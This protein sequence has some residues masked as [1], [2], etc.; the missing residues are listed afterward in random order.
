MTS[1]QSQAQPA[2]PPILKSREI[3]LLMR[4]R[5]LTLT[6]VAWGLLIYFMRD[7]W[8]LAYEY[9]DDLLLDIDPSNLFHWV[10]IWTRIAPFF[11]VAAF[12][13]AWVVILSLLRRRAI[14]HTGR[15]RGKKSIRTVQQHFTLRPL[16]RSVLAQKF[17][18]DPNQLETWQELRAVDVSID[19][20][21]NKKRIVDRTLQK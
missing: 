4:A 15:I 8:F 6:L 9:I 19:E 5:D 11:Y 10:A 18:V 21:S 3:P 13:V 2:W 20:A 7:L 17:E 1:K 14:H 16:E 12:L